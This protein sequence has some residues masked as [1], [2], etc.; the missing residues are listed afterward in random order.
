MQHFQFQQLFMCK[1]IDYVTQ[2]NTS[3]CERDAQR[4]NRVTKNILIVSLLKTNKKYKKTCEENPSIT[5]FL[6]SYKGLCDLITTRRT[7]FKRN[8][9]LKE[10]SQLNSKQIVCFLVRFQ[11]FLKQHIQS[12]H[13]CNESRQIEKLFSCLYIQYRH[14]FKGSEQQ[15]ADT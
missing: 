8:S 7:C 13:I 2:R 6:V 15:K 14:S 9:T 4:K 10:K 3:F 1:R 11:S 12:F 5:S